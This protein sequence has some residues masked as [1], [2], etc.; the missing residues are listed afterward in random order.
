MAAPVLQYVTIDSIDGLKVKGRLV[1]GWKN[2]DGK[3][4]SVARVT[5]VPVLPA[6]QKTSPHVKFYPSA[7]HV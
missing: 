7:H 5:A 4:V 2:K 1:L 6:S 3:D